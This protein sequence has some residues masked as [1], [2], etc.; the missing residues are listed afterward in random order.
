MAAPS[1]RTRSHR[2]NRSRIQDAFDIT[3]LRLGL[4]TGNNSPDQTGQ[5]K[6][7]NRRAR[8]KCQLSLTIDKNICENGLARTGPS[9]GTAA[10]ISG[11][12]M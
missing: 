1:C 3:P 11:V 12:T 10:L 8:K 5:N 6:L 9:F 7:P 2:T 4:N